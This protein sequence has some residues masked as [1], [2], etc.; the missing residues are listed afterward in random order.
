MLEVTLQ[1]AFTKIIKV[2]DKRKK[3]KVQNDVYSSLTFVLKLLCKYIYP[4][5]ISGR[6]QNPTLTF[7]CTPFSLF[8][9]FGHV[10]VV[11]LGQILEEKI[12]SH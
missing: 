9:F 2:R 11:L 4:E 12:L 1:E 6:I 5:T 7:Y 8:E 10:C 3:I